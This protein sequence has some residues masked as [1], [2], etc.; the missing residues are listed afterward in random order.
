M[1]FTTK[2]YYTMGGITVAVRDSAGTGSLNYLLGDQLGSTTV[3]INAAGGTPV[4][5][6]YLP[7]G[8]PRSTTAGTPSPTEAGSARPKTTAP[9]C[10]TSTPA[11]TTPPS[12]GSPPSTRWPT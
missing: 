6:R 4:V 12:A 3:S 10:S 8:A 5:Q 9:V 7:Y 2:R 1:T 11:T